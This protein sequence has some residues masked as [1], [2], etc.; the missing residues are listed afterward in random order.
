MIDHED[1]LH[2]SRNLGISCKYGVSTIVT[3]EK[4]ADETVLLVV[5]SFRPEEYTVRL[6]M[7]QRKDMKMGL[8][9]ETGIA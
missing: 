3:E 8:I 4:T 2:R 1:R 7:L 9:Q 6:S 5:L